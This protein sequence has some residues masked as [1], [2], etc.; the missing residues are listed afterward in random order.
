MGFLD[1]DNVVFKDLKVLI[2]KVVENLNFK[3]I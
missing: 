3:V 1:G 2:N